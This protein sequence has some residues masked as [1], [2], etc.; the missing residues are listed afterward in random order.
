MNESSNPAPLHSISLFLGRMVGGR[1][2]VT[3]ESFM[4]WLGREVIMLIPAFSVQDITYAVR[5]Q[6]EP[7]TILTWIAPITPGTQ[8]VVAQVAQSYRARFEQDSVLVTVAPVAAFSFESE[9][10]ETK[11][12]ETKSLLVLPGE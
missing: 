5:G 1:H 6:A 7:T 9:D 10:K 12:N 8:M 2:L 4:D 3:E 11:V